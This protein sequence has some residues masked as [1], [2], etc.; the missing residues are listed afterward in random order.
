MLKKSILFCGLLL[1]TISISQTP[2][3]VLGYEVDTICEYDYGYGVYN[4]V[5]EDLNNDSTNILITGFGSF[6]DFASVYG[7]STYDPG[8]SLRT[9][10][11]EVTSGALPPGVTLSSITINIY[12]GALDG[13]PI[14]YTLNGIGLR[15]APVITS[16][17]SSFTFCSNGNPVDPSPYVSPDG[18][19]IQYED[20]TQS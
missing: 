11:I 2:P 10:Q 17:F 19:M 9:F 1:G 13:A 8:S 14:G 18:G 7:P 6:I 5:I 4:L 20:G 16:D 3:T 12:G 15:Q